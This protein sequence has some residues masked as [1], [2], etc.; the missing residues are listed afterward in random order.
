MKT[1][2]SSNELL[3]K[4]VFSFHLKCIYDGQHGKRDLLYTTISPGTSNSFKLY[5]KISP[6]RIIYIICGG[7]KDFQDGW[8]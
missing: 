3:N 7:E 2:L 1:G 4:M 8:L 5:S 6:S